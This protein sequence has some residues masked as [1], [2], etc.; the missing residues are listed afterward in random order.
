MSNFHELLPQKKFTAFTNKVKKMA[1][2]STFCSGIAV[3][4]GGI[5]SHDDYYPKY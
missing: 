1:F 5:G 2:P 4:A 3:V